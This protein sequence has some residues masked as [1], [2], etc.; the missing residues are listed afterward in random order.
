MAINGPNLNNFSL[1]TFP[2]N[3]GDIELSVITKMNHFFL[4]VFGEFQQLDKAIFC[5]RAAGLDPFMIPCKVSF[6]KKRQ[7]PRKMFGQS[8]NLQCTA[9]PSFDFLHHQFRKCNLPENEYND[10]FNLRE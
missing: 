8:Q 2:V 5:D 3:G 6:L 10:Y 4:F 7:I 9:I 1:R